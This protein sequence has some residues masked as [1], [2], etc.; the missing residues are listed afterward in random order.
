MFASTF[1][2]GNSRQGVVIVGDG[3]QGLCLLKVT[4]GMV[5]V[6]QTAHVLGCKRR[7]NVSVWFGGREAGTECLVANPE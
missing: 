6:R 1:A 2:E 3:R 4:I 7:Q 5:A